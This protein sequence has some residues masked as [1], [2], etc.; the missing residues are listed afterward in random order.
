M[1]KDIIIPQDANTLTKKWM[2]RL[3]AASEFRIQTAGAR[4]W[5][6]FRRLYAQGGETE[7][8]AA[9]NLIYISVNAMLAHVCPKNIRAV[10]QPHH[11]NWMGQSI[12]LQRALDQCLERLDPILIIRDVMKNSALFPDAGR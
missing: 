3:K 12:V 10:V 6:S 11:P 8:Q 7:E 5:D 9:A 1:P 2:Q 4:Q